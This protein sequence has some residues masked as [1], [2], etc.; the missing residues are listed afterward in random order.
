VDGSRQRAGAGVSRTARRCARTRSE[1]EAGAGGAGVGRATAQAASG[2]LAWGRQ[3]TCAAAGGA[4][5]PS[6][7]AKPKA[8]GEQ[9]A[10]AR[11]CWASR[12][13]G[14]AVEAAWW[15]SERR[16]RRDAVLVVHAGE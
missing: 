12:S 10:L 3:Q 7:G 13:W 8:S 1:R 2:T 14:I 9:T 4:R 5:E 16:R 11:G 6:A 15:L